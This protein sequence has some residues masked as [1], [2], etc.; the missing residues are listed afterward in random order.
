[1]WKNAG[2]NL[3]LLTAALS[4]IPREISE[5]ASLDGARGLSK[6]TRITL[7]M[8]APALFFSGVMSV[9]QSL[10][11]FKE[12]YLLYGAYPDP[13]IYLVQHY[14]NNHFAKLNYQNLTA[15]AIFFALL[16][17]AVVALYYWLERRWA[18]EV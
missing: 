8:I 5:A 14:M 6:L 3:I 12:T 15:G 9:M 16:V 13:S 10:R 7:P 1:M 18:L 11:V 17:G 2:Y 4:M